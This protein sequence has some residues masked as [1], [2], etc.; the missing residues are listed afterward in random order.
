MINKQGFEQQ[1]PKMYLWLNRYITEYTC[2]GLL[3]GLSRFFHEELKETT[4]VLRPG[5]CT[6]G[7]VLELKP[8]E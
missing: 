8:P 6:F 7:A 2:R 4:K 5:S 1:L 3:E